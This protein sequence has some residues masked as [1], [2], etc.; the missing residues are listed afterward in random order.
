MT[1]ETIKNL[2]KLLP[3]ETLQITKIDVNPMVIKGIL[4]PREL[5]SP[6]VSAE[7]DT[8]E[9]CEILNVRIVA[10]ISTTLLGKAPIELYQD[11]ENEQNELNLIVKYTSSEIDPVEYH[12]W[13][14]C[15]RHEIK[16]GEQEI[17]KV[18]TRLEN[19]YLE[20]TN[21][22]TSRGTVTHVLQS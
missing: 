12:A 15:Y 2:E 7:K 9:N 13:V 6:L 16:K 14:I 10:L 22:K 19:S 17:I 1:P 18:A 20:N 11:T 5:L 8:T 4:Q 21:P 3:L